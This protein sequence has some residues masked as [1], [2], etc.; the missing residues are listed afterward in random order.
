MKP[1]IKLTA[2]G[3]D[4]IGGIK[5]KKVL[6]GVGSIIDAKEIELG[7]YLH[8]RKIKCTE[9]RSVGAMVTTN[10]VTESIEKIYELMNE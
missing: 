6:I 3:F 1:I 2:T 9:I 8:S 4:E 10:Y 7:T 5:S